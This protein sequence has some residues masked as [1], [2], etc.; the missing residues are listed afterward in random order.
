MF[1][2]QGKYKFS[3]IGWGWDDKIHSA[4]GGCLFQG[5]AKNVI[6]IFPLGFVVMM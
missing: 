4:L 2:S 1:L 5:K 6:I 3:Y